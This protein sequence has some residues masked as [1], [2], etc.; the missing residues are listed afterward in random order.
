[1]NYITNVVIE[2]IVEHLSEGIQRGIIE[3]I[4][5]TELIMKFPKEL[6][7]AFAEI[8]FEAIPK[9]NT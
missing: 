1:M 7:K 8:V 6:P 5:K 9:T 3:K 4:P 2:V